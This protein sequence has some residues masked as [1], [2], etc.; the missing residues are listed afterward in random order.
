MK[1]LLALN[2]LALQILLFIPGPK[3][4]AQDEARAIWQV[5]NFDIAANVLQSDRTLAAVAILTIKNVGRAAGSG[6]TLRI[7]SKAKINSVSANGAAATFHALPDSR[8]NLQRLNLSLPAT[9]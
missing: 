4:A 6:L 9:A 7:T 3:A 1:T 2:I 5:T 8:P